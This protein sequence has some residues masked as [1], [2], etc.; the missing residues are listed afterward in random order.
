MERKVKIEKV[1]YKDSPLFCN[2]KLF[3]DMDT[4]LMKQN[5]ATGS[6]YIGLTKK[7]A[8][9]TYSLLGIALEKK[10]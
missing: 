5:K 3:Q 6:S 7:E 10:G 9:S 4:E 8:E 2:L 1:N